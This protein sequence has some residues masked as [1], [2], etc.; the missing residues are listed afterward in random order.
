[1]EVMA[2]MRVRGDGCELDWLGAYHSQQL[3][4]QLNAVTLA[5][6]HSR[7]HSHP[8]QDWALQR[9]AAIMLDGTHRVST[10]GVNAETFR[11]SIAHQCTCPVMPGWVLWWSEAIGT[12]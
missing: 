7:S 4:H 10:P 3:L 9:S 12:P 11:K 2:V 1:M 8:P 6:P 5:P